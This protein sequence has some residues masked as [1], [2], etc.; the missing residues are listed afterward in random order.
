MKKFPKILFF[1]SFLFLNVGIAWSQVKIEVKAFD[2]NTIFVFYH[3]KDQVLDIKAKGNLINVNM[4]TPS[5]FVVINPRDFYKFA[6][7]PALS[8][9]KK[10]IYLV[11][12]EKFEFNNIINGEKLTAIKFRS[13]KDETLDLPTTTIKEEQIVKDNDSTNIDAKLQQIKYSFFKDEHHL[14]FDVGVK[15]IGIASFVRGKYLWVILDQNKKFTLARNKIFTDFIQLENKDSTILRIK[16][17]DYNNV[18]LIKNGF[19]FALIASKHKSKNKGTIL[20]VKN[21]P[22]DDGIKIDGN[23]RNNKIVE[24]NDPEIGDLIKLLPLK[25]YN[26]RIEK[27]IETIDFNIVPTIQGVVVILSSDDVQFIKNNN[28][29]LISSKHSLS[30]ISNESDIKLQKLGEIASTKTVINNFSN[31]TL[32]PILDKK[33]D[34]IDF[35]Y[36]KSRLIFE[37][38]LAENNEQKFAKRFE[39]AKFLFMHG[40]YHESLS[41]LK[42]SKDTTAKEYNSNLQARFLTGVNY[43]LTGFFEEAKDVYSQLLQNVNDSQEIILWNN[44]NEFLIGHNPSKL[45]FLNNLQFVNVYPDNIYW[46]IALAEIDLS[47]LS[48]N[49]KEVELLSK[50]LRTPEGNFANSLNYY[51]ANYY[52]KQRQFDLAK[53]SLQKLSQ[54]LNDPFNMVRSRI[55][56]IKLQIAQKEINFKEAIA[57]LNNLRFIWRGDKLEYELLM[58]IAGYYRDN[59]QNIKACRTYKY[60]RHAFPNGISNFYITSEMVKIFNN[61]F[62]PKDGSSGMD[63]FSVVALFYEFKDMNPIGTQGD[64]VILTIAKKLINLDLLDKATDLLK[65]QVLYRLTGEKRIVHADCLAILLLMNKKPNEAIKILDETEKDN[66]KFDE[67]QHRSRLRAKALID[68]KKYNEALAYLTNDESNDASILRRECLFQTKQWHQYINLVEPLLNKLVDGIIDEGGKQDIVR[69]AIAY[70]M[71]NNQEALEK[72]SKLLDINNEKL[73]NTIDLLLIDNTH[74][75]YANLDKSLNINQMQ[76]IFDKYKNQIFDQK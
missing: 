57:Q 30:T 24:F 72:L 26:T 27:L 49:L 11:T 41:S 22:D 66:F 14:S 48:N 76:V 51:K 15:N 21:L 47:L 70:N 29:L 37:S 8:E 44:Y 46:S 20:S 50:N 40:W 33:L 1:F 28:S 67:H 34:I 43:T 31:T 19:N 13:E 62:L 75:D 53:Q 10:S 71:Q 69:L 68:L 23:F 17:N 74:I 55:E 45:G 61:A 65:H 52:R 3:N 59:N 56:L 58:L 36:N 4:K 18:R 64:E 2:G 42:L 60:I 16:I 5:D 32:L 54:E 7:H 73:K 6:E 12:K 38:S 9:D 35:N 39:L 25:A 63:D